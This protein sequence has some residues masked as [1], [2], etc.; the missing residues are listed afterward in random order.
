MHPLLIGLIVTLAIVIV[1][2]AAMWLVGP[3]R[4]RSRDSGSSPR[5]VAVQKQKPTAWGAGNRRDWH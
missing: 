5:Q 3:W 2:L 1:A 4:P